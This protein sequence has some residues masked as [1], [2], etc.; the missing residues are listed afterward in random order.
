M[1]ELDRVVKRY[2]ATLAVDAVT[3]S[4]KPGRILGLLGPNGAGKTSTL[5]IVNNIIKPDAGTIRLDDR[6]VGRETRDR[7]ADR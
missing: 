2:G 6:I 3:F 1:L 5:R 7:R 4:A